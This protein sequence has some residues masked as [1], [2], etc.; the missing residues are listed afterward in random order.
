M[1]DLEGMLRRASAADNWTDV[2]HRCAWCKRVFDANGGYATIVPFDGTTVATDGI[3][4]RCGARALAEI[5]GRQR[6]RAA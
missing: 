2:V 5:T 4:P 1:A 6:R 3:C